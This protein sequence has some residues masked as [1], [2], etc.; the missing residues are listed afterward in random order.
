MAGVDDGQLAFDFDE[1]AREEARANMDQWQGA[2][3]HYTVDY[4]PPGMLEEAVKHWIFLNGNMG[5]YQRSH[6]WHP[7]IANNRTEAGEH[8]ADVF[9]ADLRPDIG[10]EGPGAL[11]YQAI[12][13]PCGWHEIGAD[14]NAVVEAWHDHAVPGW[15]DLPV[16]PYQVRAFSETGLTK[17]GRAWITARYPEDMQVPG[18]P[19]ITQRLPYGT[20]HV[21][22]RSPWGGYDLS[23]T[24][25][26]PPT[27]APSTRPAVTRQLPDLRPSRTH[28]PTP[29]HSGPAIGQ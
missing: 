4:Y 26:E 19:I 15:R 21:P 9:T 11:L 13:E 12:C 17:V 24:A 5:A 7:A 18:A 29:R 3:L 20:R 8:S 1:L 27:P 6:M 16:I 2:P 28:D 25:L 22:S 14:E 23:H 10:H